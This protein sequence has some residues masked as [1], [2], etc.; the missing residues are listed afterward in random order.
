MPS[1]KSTANRKQE[2]PPISRAWARSTATTGLGRGPRAARRD[3]VVGLVRPEAFADA[4]ALRELGRRAGRAPRGEVFCRVATVGPRYS[5]RVTRTRHQDATATTA[6]KTPSG[7]TAVNRDEPD[8][9]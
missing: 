9:A 8:E 6:T 5:G 1:P 4:R 7:T 2:S 3:V